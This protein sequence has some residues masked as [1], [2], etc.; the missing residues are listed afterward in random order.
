[1]M[2]DDAGMDRSILLIGS[3][4]ATL[5]T[6]SLEKTTINV[7]LSVVFLLFTG[8]LLIKRLELM[9]V[10]LA[11]QVDAVRTD[12]ENIKKELKRGKNNE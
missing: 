12:I 9:R 5:Y 3:I 4:I 8:F 7:L 6:A 11:P 1:M 2:E 10:M